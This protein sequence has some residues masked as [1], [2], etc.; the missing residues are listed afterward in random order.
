MSTRCVCCSVRRAFLT[1]LAGLVVSTGCGG[2]GREP[3]SRQAILIMLDAA[4]PDRFSAYGYARETTPR[5]DRLADNGL[6]FQNHFAQATYTRAS[7]PTLFYSR[8]FAKSMFPASPSIPLT[9]PDDLFRVP[10]EQTLSLARTLSADGILTAVVSAHPWIKRGT[11]FADDFDELH[12]LANNAAD[13]RVHPDAET[14]IDYAIDW[15]GEHLE[16][17]YF[18]YIH[19]MDTHTPHYFDADARAYFGPEPYTGDRFEPLGNPKNVEQPLSREDRRYLDALYDGSLR[20]N[21]RELGRLFDYLAERGRL[22]NTLIIV[23]ADHGEHLMEVAGR[24]GHECDW[25][26]AVARIPLLVYYPRKLARG[27]VNAPSE[28]VDISPTVLDL[29]DV[30]FPEGKATDGVDLVPY[31]RGEADAKPYVMA[32]QA[33]RSSQFKCIF[34]DPDAVLLA[35]AAPAVAGLSGRLYDVRA[36][37]LET[38]DLWTVRPDVVQTMLDA[39]RASMAPRFRRY[40]AAV[41]FTQPEVPFALGTNHARI[42]A[43]ARF[44]KR[45]P[46]DEDCGGDVEGEPWLISE[47]DHKHWLMARRGAGPCRLEIAVPEGEYRLS[48]RVMGRGRMTVEGSDEVFDIAGIDFEPGKYANLRETHI[49]YV[50]VTGDVFRARLELPPDSDCFFLR[51][52]GFSPVASDEDLAEDQALDEARIERLRSLGY[53]D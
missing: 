23:T 25:Y 10:D 41:R 33:I 46:R 18:L 17:D 29:L 24:Y 48:A 26:D 39:Y 32:R 5:M 36:D 51:I 43:E 34:A 35:D 52:L 14:M 16:Q 7:L 40:Q 45:A 42:E 53:V 19:M 30:P 9:E 11:D 6:I 50:T 28:G 44:V 12:D 27:G 21:D 22:E 49:G 37:V 4:R 15:L 47:H 38:R 31:A 8:Y 1:L 13:G 2:G 20:Y 3:G